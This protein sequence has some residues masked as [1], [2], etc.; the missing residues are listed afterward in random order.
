MSMRVM[1][2]CAVL[3]LGCGALV[4]ST[5]CDEDLVA[6]DGNVETGGQATGG[7]GTAA[8]GGEGGG[9]GTTTPATGGRGSCYEE[10]PVLPTRDGVA[11]DNPESCPLTPPATTACEVM[12]GSLC[13][14]ATED[15]DPGVEFACVCTLEGRTG[16]SFWNCVVEDLPS[17]WCREL[18]PEEGVSCFGYRGETC[19]GCSC[20]DDDEAVWTC[21]GEAGGQPGAERFVPELAVDATTPINALTDN[22]RTL[23]CQWLHDFARG[24]LGYPDFDENPLDDEG[25]T[26]NVGCSARWDYPNPVLVPELPSSQCVGNLAISTCEAT[27]AELLECVNPTYLRYGLP[28]PGCGPYLAKP[29]CDGTVLNENPYDKCLGSGTADTPACDLRVQ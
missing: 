3:V 10:P 5:G 22:E 17:T 27:V 11:L 13:R 6:D 4:S 12:D 14:Y 16:R 29:G 15:T 18:T 24:G 1:H 23:L 19:Q 2:C 20:S 28:Y 7:V 21:P 9:G 8:A 25:Y 26:T